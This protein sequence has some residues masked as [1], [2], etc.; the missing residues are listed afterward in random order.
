MFYHWVLSQ[1]TCLSSPELRVLDA[2]HDD[3][4]AHTGNATSSDQSWNVWLMWPGNK[5]YATSISGAFGFKLDQIEIA[6]IWYQSCRTGPKCF[7]VPPISAPKITCLFVQQRDAIGNRREYHEPLCCCSSL[8]CSLWGPLRFHH[9]AH[10][11][12]HPF[13]PIRRFAI[14]IL[15][16]SP[17]L[18]PDS[19]QFQRVLVRC[20]DCL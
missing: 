6:A 9:N 16:P 10:P 18:A 20:R 3:Q 8:C 12:P 1:N 7:A 11:L 19:R 5:F 4:L 13:Y 2:E 15:W 14:A 17:R